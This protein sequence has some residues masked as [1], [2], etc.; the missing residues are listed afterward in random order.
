VRNGTGSFPAK[1]ALVTEEGETV[2][3]RV[4]RTKPRDVLHFPA[5]GQMKTVRL[6]PEDRYPDLAPADNVWPR[7]DLP[8]RVSKDAIR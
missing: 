5:G 6:D 3:R 2:V 1:V 7:A 4:D 8:V